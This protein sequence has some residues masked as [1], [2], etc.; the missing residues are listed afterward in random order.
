MKEKE[1]ISLFVGGFIILV[2][3]GAGIFSEIMKGFIG[4]FGFSFGILLGG[5]F[6]LMIIVMFLGGGK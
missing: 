1:I 4:A 2:L 6:S 3:A 5:L